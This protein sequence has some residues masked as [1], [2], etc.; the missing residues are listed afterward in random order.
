MLTPPSGE[1]WI[2]LSG[3]PLAAEEARAW[4]TTPATGAQV[5]F[6]GTVRDNAE[7]RSDVVALEYEAYDEQVEAPL[8]AIADEVRSRWPDVE[9]VALLHRVGRL[10]LTEIAVVVAVGAGHRDAAFDAGRFAIDSLKTS[11]P[12]WK[13]EI[14]S[15]G[16]AWGTNA[17]PIESRS[18]SVRS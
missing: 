18:S 4:V 12:I 13:K 1:T 8:L 3:D 11:V 15:G 16:E 6:T 14:W 17:N 5:V 2:G 9:R 7:G 10:G